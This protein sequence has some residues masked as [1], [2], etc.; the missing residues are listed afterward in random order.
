MSALASG[1]S[2]NYTVV[3][4]YTRDLIGNISPGVRAVQ[5]YRPGE[6]KGGYAESGIITG[7]NTNLGNKWYAQKRDFKD[8]LIMIPFNGK[9]ALGARHL[10]DWKVYALFNRDEN[11]PG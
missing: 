1:H 7:S 2:G 9:D 3:A 5:K 10:P 8:R 11:Q 4:P 6:S